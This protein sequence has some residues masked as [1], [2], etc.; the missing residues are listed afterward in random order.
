[1]LLQGLREY[2]DVVEID[3]DEFVKIFGENEVH[4]TLVSRNTILEAKWKDAAKW[5]DVPMVMTVSSRKRRFELRCLIH[6]DLPI[7]RL[8]VQQGKV[9]GA[10]KMQER[11]VDLG[12][13]VRVFDGDC[14]E[15]SIIDANTGGTRPASPL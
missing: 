13:R 11:F 6:P 8:H 15:G 14:V 5:K 9:L 4:L 12:D 7:T 3:E 10:R 1:M 2:Q